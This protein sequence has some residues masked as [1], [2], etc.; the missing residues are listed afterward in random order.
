MPTLHWEWRKSSPHYYFHSL[1]QFEIAEIIKDLE[2]LLLLLF[3]VGEEETYGGFMLFC[4]TSLTMLHVQDDLQLLRPSTMYS[5]AE[6]Y[7]SGS[8]DPFWT[9]PKD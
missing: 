6:F 9:E 5:L 4:L 3:F 1:E 7:L 8:Y 2:L